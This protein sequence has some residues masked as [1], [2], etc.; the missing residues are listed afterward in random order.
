MSEWIRSPVKPLSMNQAYMG[1]K[2][3]TVL[4][5]RYEKELLALLPAM[6]V[7]ENCELCLHIRADF[8]NRRMDLDNCLKPFIDIL[9][10][11]Y[12]FND[13]RVYCII[14][15]KNIVSK[16]MEGIYFKLT[17]WKDDMLEITEGERRFLLTLLSSMVEY[18]EDWDREEVAQAMELLGELRPTFDENQLELELKE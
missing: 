10:T 3:K 16:G 9:Q 7:P 2:R 1:R 14:V 4:Y 11:Q 5:K 17:E 15:K 12:N 13:N 8:S 18:D 6:Y